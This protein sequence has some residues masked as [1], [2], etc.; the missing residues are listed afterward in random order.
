MDIPKE[1]LEVLPELSVELSIRDIA[2]RHPSET[3]SKYRSS[4]MRTSEGV[5]AASSSEIAGFGMSQS[6]SADDTVLTQPLSSSIPIRRGLYFINS[7]LG[8]DV[9]L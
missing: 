5:A 6:A 4:A 1:G 9:C 2:H 3:L 7:V 8:F